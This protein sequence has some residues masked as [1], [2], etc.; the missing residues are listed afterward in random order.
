MNL[1]SY[2]L[3]QHMQAAWSE[4][5]FLNDVL[6]EQLKILIV[7]FL[8]CSIMYVNL[9]LFCFDLSFTIL[10]FHDKEMFY[11]HLKTLQ[12]VKK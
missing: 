7:G 2:S 4:L 11:S 8:I 5:K 6:Y 3:K 12:L 1:T 9:A 10:F